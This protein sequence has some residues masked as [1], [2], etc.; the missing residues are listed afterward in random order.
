MRAVAVRAGREALP[1]APAPWNREGYNTLQRHLSAAQTC[2]PFAAHIPNCLH[3]FVTLGGRFGDQL[4]GPRARINREGLWLAR[5]GDHSHFGSRQVNDVAHFGP[6]I[7]RR[8]WAPCGA[9]QETLR[10]CSAA[11]HG[12]KWRHP[13]LRWVGRRSISGSP[14]A[15]QTTAASTWASR[16]HSP[17]EDHH[18]RTVSTAALHNWSVGSAPNLELFALLA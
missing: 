10:E 16:I 18:F 14:R 7:V 11:R 1:A 3:P 2:M 6:C 9:R 15:A 13:N 5:L 8:L 12:C 4:V 17:I